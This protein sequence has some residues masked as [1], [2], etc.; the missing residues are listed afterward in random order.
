MPHKTVLVDPNDRIIGFQEVKKAHFNPVPLHRAISVIIFNKKGD[1]MLIHQRAQNKFT[2]PG[3][4]T[5][6]C[7][8]NVRPSETYL[9]CAK[10]RLFEEMGIRTPLKKLFKFTYQAEYDQTYGENEVDTVFKGIYEGK[11]IPDPAEIGDYKWIKLTS[12]KKDIQNNPQ[13][14]TP[15]F[16]IIM[17]KLST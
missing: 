10:R 4:W 8:T 6:T 16:K 9:A 1:Q 5:N 15:W 11:I 2:W 12:L 13:F 14:Y 17:E 7:C 3:F